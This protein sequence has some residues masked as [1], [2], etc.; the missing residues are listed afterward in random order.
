M[1]ALL[2]SVVLVASLFSKCAPE[3][4]TEG[5]PEDTLKRLSLDGETYVEEEMKMAL[6]GV[7]QMKEVMEKNEEKHAHLMRSLR[8]SSEKKKGA[9][10]MAKEV[11]QKL[12]EAEQQ[13]K[14][15]LKASWEECRPCLED[16]CKTFYTST[17]RRGFSTFSFKV[18]DF[19]R[20]T[21]A[22][23][24]LEDSQGLVQS[25][26]L[27]LENSDVEMMQVEDSF[28]QL[29]RRV[30]I[31]YEKSMELVTN[32]RR[33]FDC[34]FRDAFIAS[35]K[36][37]PLLPAPDVLDADFLKGIGLEEVLDSFFD[38][39]KSML[40]EFSSVITE[41][42]E[43]IQEAVQEESEL[44][45]GADV[46]PSWATIQSKKLC[47]DLRRQTSECWQLQGQCE[48]CQRTVT[49]ECPSV[50]ELHRELNE[51]SDLLSVSSQQYQEVLQV[52]QRHTDDTFSWLGDMVSRFSWVVELA[53]CTAVSDSVFNITAVMPHKQLGDSASAANTTVEV[54][55]LNSP[56]FTLN[57]PAELE[58]QDRAFVQ[59][60]TREALG[61]YKQMVRNEN[62]VA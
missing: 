34:T 41:V 22:Q 49:Q 24:Q 9:M 3:T 36:P 58:V 23:F 48:P 5:L 28:G 11:E 12:A 42:F 39:G 17:C 57:V 25:Q 40:E 37:K 43:D 14:E 47:R 18:E 16:A 62:A 6:F 44:Q 59:Y 20:K 15:A 13:C 60:V 53:N 1:R 32:M 2:V 46:F 26:G 45:K 30:S 10:E 21:S 31:L 54:N 51:V 19:F 61:M 56:T 52:V 55:F 27:G 8:H 33:K 50:W 7:K 35:L 29:Q 38:F 4:F